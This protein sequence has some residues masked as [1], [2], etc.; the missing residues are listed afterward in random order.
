LFQPNDLIVNGR[1]KGSEMSWPIEC[2]DNKL[3]SNEAD[4][5]NEI[6]RVHYTRYDGGAEGK[7]VLSLHGYDFQELWERATNQLL[8]NCIVF[9]GVTGILPPDG[10]S[11]TRWLT[12]NAAWLSVRN[13]QFQFNREKAIGCD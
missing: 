6:G 2:Y 11:S 12:S 1:F 3:P 13:L 9:I 5:E 10:E 7:I 4:S 8:G